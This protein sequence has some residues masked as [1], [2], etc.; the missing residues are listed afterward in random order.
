MPATSEGLFVFMSGRRSAA[1]GRRLPSTS[2]AWCPSSRRRRPRHR[3]PSWAAARSSPSPRPA[4]RC[5]CRCGCQ[6]SDTSPAG[7]VE[8]LERYEGMRVTA[9]LRVIGADRRHGSRGR[10][11]RRVERAVLRGDRRGAPAG[12]RARP[13]SACRGA[14]GP[15]LLRA[16]V[17]RQPGTAAGRQR[18]ADR[19]RDP[20]RRRRAAARSARSACSTSRSA[21]TASCRIPAPATVV[22]PQQATPV[23]V[24]SAERVHDRVGQ[25]GTVLRRSGRSRSRRRRC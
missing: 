4:S 24:P 9:D 15:A 3:S 16:A 10:G 12:P 13:R 1:G 19:Q 18:G 2:P 21:P 23:P 17:R 20:R 22:G 14:A 8:Q 11:A 25:P 5:H 6:P 7:G